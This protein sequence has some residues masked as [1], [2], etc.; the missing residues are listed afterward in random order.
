MILSP[1]CSD[2]LWVVFSILIISYLCFKTKV[3]PYHS[4]SFIILSLHLKL[5]FCHFPH[6]SIIS[7]NMVFY[8]R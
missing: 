5:H 8:L 4:R 2:S 3:G 7:Q 6:H 1:I